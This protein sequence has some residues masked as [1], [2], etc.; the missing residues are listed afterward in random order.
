[1]SNLRKAACTMSDQSRN[2]EARAELNGEMQKFGLKPA[3]APANP[4]KEGEAAVEEKPETPPKEAEKPPKEP[5][6]RVE[7]PAEK[8]SE[9]ED[10]EPEK[11]KADEGNKDRPK[12]FIPLPQYLEEKQKHKEEIKTLQ[13]T[14]AELNKGKTVDNKSSVEK[15]IQDEIRTFAEEHGLADDVISELINLASKPTLKVVEELKRKVDELSNPK[16][17]EKTKEQIL[18]EENA[19]F[20]Q[21]WNNFDIDKH[22]SGLTPEQKEEAKRVMDELAHTKEWHRYDLDYIF[23]KNRGEFEDAVGTKQFKGSGPSKTQG[24]STM[25]PKSPND[26]PRLSDNPTPAEIKEYEGYMSNIL[27]RGQL[28]EKP[29]DTL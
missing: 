21:E 4:N 16:A 25:K 3:E 14:I 6:E 5:K 11:P 19:R 1:M 22:L 8:E 13:E 10:E 20:E 18:A 26:K 28:S 27:N 12:K 9:K 15:E 23:F 7:R 2:D 24:I 17:P 29:N